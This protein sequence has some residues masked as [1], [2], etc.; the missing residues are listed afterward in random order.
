M[1]KIVFC[2]VAIIVCCSIFATDNV[3]YGIIPQ[4]KSLKEMAGEFKVDK[5][6]VIIIPEGDTLV[7]KMAV[8]FASR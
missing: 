5:H 1:K 6:T 2:T 4:P 7:E 8:D 3:R